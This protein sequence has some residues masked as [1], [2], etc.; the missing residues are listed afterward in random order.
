M[1]PRARNQHVLDILPKRLVLLEV[2]HGRRPAARFVGD[3]LNSD[4]FEKWLHP[5]FAVKNAGFEDST[6]C[7]APFEPPEIAEPLPYV[8]YAQPVRT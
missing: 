3:E 2:D 7:Q 8:V 1:P 4:H 6:P 5:R